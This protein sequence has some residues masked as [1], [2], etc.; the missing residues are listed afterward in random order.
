[1]VD[2][3]DLNYIAR[4]AFRDIADQDYITARW[5]YK[6]RLSI[7]FCWMAQQCIEKY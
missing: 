3:N 4:T 1:M 5:C 7:Q 2:Q 6:S